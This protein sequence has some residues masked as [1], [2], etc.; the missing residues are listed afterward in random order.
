[1]KQFLAIARALALYGV[2]FIT[3]IRAVARLIRDAFNYVRRNYRSNKNSG[4]G[5]PRSGKSD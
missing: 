4:G 2:P 3:A 5:N 1:M